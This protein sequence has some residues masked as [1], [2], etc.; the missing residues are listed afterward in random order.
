MFLPIGLKSFDLEFVQ[1]P[2]REFSPL[3][4]TPKGAVREIHWDFEIIVITT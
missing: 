3:L 2:V 1:P 4:R